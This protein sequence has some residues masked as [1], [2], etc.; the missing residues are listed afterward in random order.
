M[1]YYNVIKKTVPFFAAVFILSHTF[2]ASKDK[3]PAVRKNLKITGGIT[4]GL[5]L[6][7]LPEHFFLNRYG[8]KEIKQK[9]NYAYI[10]SA[11]V[12]IKEKYALEIDFASYHRPTEISNYGQASLEL[13]SYTE[14][15]HIVFSVKPSVIKKKKRKVFLSAALMPGIIFFNDET[16]I[17]NTNTQKWLNADST[18]F[19]SP[20]LCLTPEFKAVFRRN[21]LGSFIISYRHVFPFQKPFHPYP[22][23]NAGISLIFDPIG[24]KF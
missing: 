23:I 15:K 10:L 11:G 14:K 7:G 5:S 17:K 2:G 22:V 20:T 21:H 8:L 9:W 3:K 1:I 19:H 16:V 18:Q 24:K 13:E 4:A 12:L 6:K